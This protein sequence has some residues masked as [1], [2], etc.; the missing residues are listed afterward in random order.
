MCVTV[1]TVSVVHVVC[2]LHV[3]VNV[4]GYAANHVHY[5]Q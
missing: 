3:C 5:V 4:S 2:T 1:A